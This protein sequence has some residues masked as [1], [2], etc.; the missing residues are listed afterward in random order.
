MSNHCSVVIKDNRMHSNEEVRASDYVVGTI[1]VGN[2]SG[3]IYVNT[4]SEYGNPAWFSLRSKGFCTISGLTVL[5]KNDTLHIE[6][7][8]D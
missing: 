1:A 8:D 2:A 4:Y 7:R 5:N 3:D 6:I